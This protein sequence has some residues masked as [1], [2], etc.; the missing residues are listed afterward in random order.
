MVFRSYIDPIITVVDRYFEKKKALSENN[1]HISGKVMETGI[2]GFS[3]CLPE[4]PC[5]LVRDKENRVQRCIYG[6]Y[7]KLVEGE[8]AE[9]TVWQEEII[10]DEGG[11]VTAVETTYPDGSKSRESIIRKDGFVAEVS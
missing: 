5:K 10:R 4:S 6:D 2:G 1:S 9:L 3:E 8:D 7:Q 11:T